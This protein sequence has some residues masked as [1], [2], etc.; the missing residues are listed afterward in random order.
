MFFISSGRFDN[1]SLKSRT[2]WFFPAIRAVHNLRCS[3]SP[4]ETDMA[5]FGPFRFPCWGRVSCDARI[6]SCRISSDGQKVALLLHTAGPELQEVYYTL[7]TTEELKPYSEIL[8]VLDDY[9]ST[10]K[11]SL[12]AACI[13][14][15]GTTKRR[16]SGSICM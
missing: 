7:V 13:Q 2:G 12:R 16:K 9:C 14:A 3:S 11:Y 6:L 4:G 8:K 1:Q 10:S 15:N 5:L